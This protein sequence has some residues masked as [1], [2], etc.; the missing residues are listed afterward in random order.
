MTQETLKLFLL[1]S[2]RENVVLEDL[3]FR[4]FMALLE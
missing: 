4:S 2:F 1:A 3:G